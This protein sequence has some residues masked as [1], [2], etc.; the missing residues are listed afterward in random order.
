MPRGRA[1]QHHGD[2]YIER[3]QY[4]QKRNEKD[5]RCRGQRQKDHRP[6]G[7][8]KRRIQHR[9][10]VA[11]PRRVNR[12]EGKDRRPDDQHHDRHRHGDDLQT[13]VPARRDQGRVAP[14]TSRAF[15]MGGAAVALR[16][17]DQFV[18]GQFGEGGVGVIHSERIYDAAL[19]CINKYSRPCGASAPAD[20][21]PRAN[22]SGT[23]DHAHRWSSRNHKG[24][25]ND[26]YHQCKDPDPRHQ[27]F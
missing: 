23:G 14:L 3:Q 6:P 2:Q 20:H 11:G 17:D 10:G 7:K 1:I 21:C 9:H 24:E 8:G 25:S 22:V 15:P 19:G 26:R 4:P 5:Q 12:K 18:H 16:T 27:R 13:C